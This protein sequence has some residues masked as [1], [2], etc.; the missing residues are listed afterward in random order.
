M[1][2]HI[3]FS[4]QTQTKDQ[5]FDNKAFLIECINNV[6]NKIENKGKLKGVFFQLD[7][8][9]RN[10]AGTPSV[11]DKMM[12]QI[13]LCD[14]FIGDMT[15][16]TPNTWWLNLGK[17]LK[18]IKGLRREPN[19]NV[20]GE[21]H[22]A[23]GKSDG[24]DEQI[25]L[26]M[27]DVNGKPE[28]DTQLIPFDSRGRR[29]PIPF[30]LKNKKQ[31][32]KAKNELAKVLKSA[33]LQSALAALK[34]IG[35]KYSPFIGWQEQ[36]KNPKLSGKF[37]WTT[38][39]RDYKEHLING[40][41]I[42]RL[43]GLSGLGK[44]KLV[45]EC[46]RDSD[47]NVHY[48]YCD[49]QRTT[50]EI[51][52]NKLSFIFKEYKEAV[53]VLD[54]CNKETL[55]RIVDLKSTTQN[56]NNTIITI[57]NEPEERQRQ[58][59]NYIILDNGDEEVVA[60]L[61]ELRGTQFND[62]QRKR[63]KEFSGGIPIMV[64]L[65][66][67]SLNRGNTLG[68]LGDQDLM[69]KLLGIKETDEKRTMIQTVALFRFIGW[70]DER[71]SELEYVAKNK[72][73]TSITNTDEEV[74]MNDF[75]ELIQ[76]CLK[77]GIMEESGRTVGL[78]PIPL[79]L[80]LI[81]EWIDKCSAERLLRVVEAIQA[82]KDSENL[83]QAFHQQ[84]KNM[85][86]HEKAREMLN[87]LLGEKSPFGNVEVINTE[88]GS[89][90]FRTF[91]EVNPIAVSN[92]LY[93]VLASLSIDELRK[94]DVGRRNLVWT[95][96]K[97]CFDSRTFH[98]G[99]FLMMRLALAE[100]EDWANNATSDFCS[101][102][103]II[104]PA[105]SANLAERLVF[106]KKYMHIEDYKEIALS[107]LARALSTSSFVYF[108]GAEKQGTTELECYSAKDSKEVE[109][110]LKGC[111]DLLLDEVEKNTYYKDKA[112]S[113]FEN[114]FRVL[115]NFG[116]VSLIL[117][118]IQKVA[119][120]LGNDWNKMQEIMSLYSQRLDK[121]LGK[122]SKQMYDSLQK[123]L[124][125]NDFVSRFSR[126]ERETY[127]ASLKTPFEERIKKQECEFEKM[128]KELVNSKIYSFE[129]LRNLMLAETN[130]TIPFGKTLAENMEKKQA[131]QFVKD[132]INV[133]NKEPK[134]KSD[135]Y[136]DFIA[137]LN[138]HIFEE[139]FHDLCELND[140]RLLFAILG[141]RSV[142]PS[143]KYFDFLL[144]MIKDG[145]VA[146][147]AFIV[148]WQHLQF[149]VMT[150]TNIVCIF[151]EIETCKKGVCCILRM[152]MMFSFGNELV[153]YPRITN[154]LKSLM[155]RFRFGSATM[156]DDYDYINIAQKI[157]S[158]G[159]ESEF[160]VE[161]H[162]EI[163]KYLSK[164]DI[165]VDY[166]YQLRDLYEVLV[167]KYFRNIWQDLSKALLSDNTSLFYLRLKDLLG[168]SAINENPVLFK[169]DHTDEFLLWCEK[170]PAMA[171][172]RLVDLMPVT[173]DNKAFTPLLLTILDKYGNQEDVLIALEDNLGT[174]AVTGS[175][176]PLFENQIGML[177]TLTKHS[178]SKVREW[179]NKQIA[180]LRNCIVNDKTV[181][182]EFWAKYK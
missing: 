61:L 89:R 156:M 51:L 168:V 175:A 181:E 1:T 155:L 30:H 124:T 50:I 22:R 16:T 42:V 96:E 173:T 76:K 177:S 73:I 98:K 23:L 62:A 154:Y 65:L 148:Y 55:N 66:I 77:R 79:A 142:L 138:N 174:F 133:L 45:L 78:R 132:G 32:K 20:Y 84:F 64:V 106:L 2:L 40:K 83:M 99:A 68:N 145:F 3:F 48:L 28:A 178:N 71:R 134:A 108:S 107:A 101:L 157:L 41:G 141:K 137:S 5:G 118:Y 128:A 149:A 151:R 60:Q 34:N 70:K 93:R 6:C 143:D 15:V 167:A 29:F 95:I 113:I 81:V 85:G 72:S 97:L 43:L 158:E 180:Y 115:C 127:H 33:I 119:E 105:T 94:I 100:N 147:D 87:K 164:T 9:L 172:Q 82:S 140:K 112:I 104:L 117:P 14:I 110:Y 59:V 57:F 92:L 54:N 109:T 162:Q 35:M 129:L 7:E 169:R 10:A 91:V 136:V 144:K 90:L 171:P 12:E 56:V 176:I 36:A 161:I 69:T 37:I 163:L 52:E 63:I 18:M 19:A 58:D 47:I 46:F 116:M 21:F 146:T 182:T 102:F 17:K 31:E 86:F 8:G 170:N 130:L 111:A 165:N 44:T 179:A 4:W 114:S 80:Y 75:D 26:V 135:F 153:K 53:L 120:I 126:I 159:E 67:D 125:K 39:L 24:F 166:D 13:D 49:S 139:V 27:N 11:A 38:K 103:P 122:E 160:A 88:L 150:E 131:I 123:L 25:I 121:H 152:A 74:M